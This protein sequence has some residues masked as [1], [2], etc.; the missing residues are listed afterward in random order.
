MSTA[1]H[2]HPQHQ[3]SRQSTRMPSTLAHEADGAS[4]G[5]QI[6][7]KTTGRYR[8]PVAVN[9]VT[10][11]GRSIGQRR[12]SAPQLIAGA[13]IAS[14]M[15]RCGGC[16]WDTFG[17]AGFLCPRSANPRAAVSITRLAASGDGSHDKGAVPMI[18]A[19]NPSALRERAA[20]HRA[21]AIAALHADSALSVRLKRYN[22]AMTKARTL[23]AQAAS[24]EGNRLSALY[25]HSEG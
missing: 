24:A 13:F 20:A 11:L 12:S 23:A 4:M 15:S 6:A 7:K 16:A 22:A 25:P 2:S 19:L 8:A 17:C 1:T 3:S 9:T 5:L 21:M 10:D 14:T 18:H